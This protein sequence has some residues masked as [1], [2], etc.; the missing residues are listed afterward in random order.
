MHFEEKM[1]EVAI[2]VFTFFVTKNIPR[3]YTKQKWLQKGAVSKVTKPKQA[4]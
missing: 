2:C 1:R 3:K 4:N